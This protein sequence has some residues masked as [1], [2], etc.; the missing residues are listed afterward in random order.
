MINLGAFNE[1]EH[2]KWLQANPGKRPKRH[3]VRKHISH[4][5]SGGDVCDLTGRSWGG[6]RGIL[7]TPTST[8]TFPLF[9]CFSGKPRNVEV[10]LKCKKSDSPSAV[11]LYLL[12]PKA[13]E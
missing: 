13:C 12:E 7:M 5:Y 10:K 6:G 1:E 8:L 2:L 9:L 11:S 3:N 4:F